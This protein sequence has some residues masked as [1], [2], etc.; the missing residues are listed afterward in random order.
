MTVTD[1]S[2]NVTT[3][4]VEVTVEDNLKPVLS[5]KD[6]TVWLDENGN[7]SI[8]AL[9]VIA[10]LSDNCNLEDTTISWS[11]FTCSDIGTHNI[12]VTVT[13]LSGNVTIDTVEVIIEDFTA[14]IIVCR[15]DTIVSA[16][17]SDGYVVQ[18]TEFDLLSV[19]EN[20]SLE[21][22]KNDINSTETLTGA[23]LPIGITTIIWTTV[24]VVGNTETCSFNVTVND[25]TGI[26]QN[27]MG[28]NMKVFPNPTNGKF[29]LEFEGYGVE[30][31]EV[32][33][34]NG[35][36]VYIK[37][38]QIQTGEI[39]DLSNQLNGIYL[40][41]IKTDKNTIITKIITIIEE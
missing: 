6:I 28:Y 21:S 18:G 41:Y 31:I 29:Q 9:D 37:Q 33:D 35:K 32:I 13:D 22:I 15:D 19:E 20:C 3:D 23:T 1:L 8:T 4:T 5:I 2:G 25:A 34:M 39:V 10:S 16:Y 14:P 27:N 40:L 26:F 30:K 24:D 17:N 38:L 36:S 12:E 7:A 11:N